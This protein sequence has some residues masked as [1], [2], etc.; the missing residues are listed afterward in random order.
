MNSEISRPRATGRVT[1][2]DVAQLAG[3]SPITVS[4]AL[5]GE[6]A[7]D[8]ALVAAMVLPL[9]PGR[10]DPRAPCAHR[11]TAPLNLSDMYEVAVAEGQRRN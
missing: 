8:P 10:S 4:R 5:R 3:V 2:A 9:I 1:L 7:V 11:P 6:R